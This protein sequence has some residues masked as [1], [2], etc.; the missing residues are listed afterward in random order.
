MADPRF[1]VRRATADDAEALSAFA[2]SVLPLG[3]RPGAD[4]RDLAH[5]VATELTPECFRAFIEDGNA[6][7]FVAKAG[8]SICGYVVRSRASPHP[9]VQD[10]PA[11]LKKL[12]VAADCHG[13]GVADALMRQALAGLER[14]GSVAVWLSTYAEN[15]RSVAFY[16][17]WGFQIV[18]TQTFMVGSDPQKD[19]LMRRN[20]L[21]RV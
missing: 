15:A 21:E 13:R 14:E 9:Q 16:K 12:Y 8:G 10:A 2:A 19:F 3:G 11:E 18:G 1:Y 17:R 5:F 20:A 7:I 6:M 4:P